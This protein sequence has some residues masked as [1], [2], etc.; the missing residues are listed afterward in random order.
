MDIE[1]QDEREMIGRRIKQ[2]REEKGFSRSAFAKRIPL[3]Q[4]MLAKIEENG[5]GMSPAILRN[6]AIRLELVEARGPSYSLSD[7]YTY[8]DIKALFIPQ[9]PDEFQMGLFSQE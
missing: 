5:V 2:L 9:L 8:E 3:N 6:I 7:D 4:D 1:R